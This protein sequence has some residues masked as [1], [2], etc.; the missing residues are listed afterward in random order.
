MDFKIYRYI[1]IMEISHQNFL[2]QTSVIDL[3]IDLFGD[4]IPKV[5]ESTCVHMQVTYVVLMHRRS[6]RGQGACSFTDVGA[7]EQ[8]V[9]P[10]S[11]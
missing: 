6:S 3:Y 7:G 9:A 8:R 1:F 11:F 2:G 5:Q 10:S 4:C